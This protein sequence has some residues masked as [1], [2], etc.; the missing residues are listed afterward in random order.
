MPQPKQRLIPHANC[1]ET[2]ETAHVLKLRPLVRRSL[3]C[4]QTPQ[5]LHLG[6]RSQRV[7]VSAIQFFGLLSLSASSMNHTN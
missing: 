7:S 4:G 1:D 3:P 2:M 6:G 5:R